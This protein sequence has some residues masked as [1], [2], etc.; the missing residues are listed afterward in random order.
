MSED[1][2]LKTCCTAVDEDNIGGESLLL[3]TKIFSNGDPIKIKN[4]KIVSGIYLNQELTLQSYS[5][6]ASFNL[7]GTVFTP[8]IL[9]RM[10]D[11]LEK[12]I[13]SIK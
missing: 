9:R 7:V 3:T 6:S 12:E 8:S 4:G 11:E 2:L 5:N 13:N 10:A 1:K